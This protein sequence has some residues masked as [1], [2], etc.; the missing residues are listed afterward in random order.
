[1]IT[2]PR[3][4]S[5]NPGMYDSER[6]S[7]RAQP[8]WTRRA[9]RA[10]HTSTAAYAF[11]KTNSSRGEK[12]VNNT[13]SHTHTK[14]NKV[15]LR[16]W[17]I[18]RMI[19][20]RV[21][22]KWAEVHFCAHEKKV[23][24]SILHSC[25]SLHVSHAHML[26]LS[27]VMSASRLRFVHAS[28]VAWRPDSHWQRGPE[29]KHPASFSFSMLTLLTDGS[30]GP[31]PGWPPPPPPLITAKHSSPSWLTELGYPTATATLHLLRWE[32]V[33]RLSSNT[34]FLQII[35]ASA[36]NP[37]HPKNQ[38]WSSFSATLP[39][40]SAKSHSSFTLKPHA[41]SLPCIFLQHSGTHGRK[42]AAWEGGK[43]A[44]LFVTQCKYAGHLLA[45]QAFRIWQQPPQILVFLIEKSFA[46]EK[47][48][49]KRCQ[50]T[51]ASVSVTE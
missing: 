20:G 49:S 47:K 35:N 39:V 17:H 27:R 6:A 11:L 9:S 30:A 36:L 25:W 12:E 45:P 48:F 46:Q 23:D 28:V 15:S 51:Q 21:F 41:I 43:T 40:T 5:R 7:E 3:R 33:M 22:L 2:P 13:L 32:Y 16:T 37:L 38:H 31:S 29:K 14:A 42:G 24:L 44:F 8:A 26:I 18:L 19:L 4:H 34:W 50:T 10:R 1:M